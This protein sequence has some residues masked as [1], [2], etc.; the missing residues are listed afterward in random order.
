MNE[1]Y[2][3]SFFNEMDENIYDTRKQQQQEHIYT[4]HQTQNIT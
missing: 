1:I 2:I 4:L 3:N